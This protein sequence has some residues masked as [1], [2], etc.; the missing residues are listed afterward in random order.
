[1]QLRKAIQPTDCKIWENLQITDAAVLTAE[2][3]HLQPNKLNS[4]ALKLEISKLQ[5][6][7][8]RTSDEI[9]RAWNKIEETIK[10]IP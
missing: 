10:E 9:R 8:P 1:M 5:H 4:G 7:I 3:H 6:K 2:K